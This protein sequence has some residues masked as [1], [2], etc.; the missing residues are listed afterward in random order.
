MLWRL[1]RATSIRT[2]LLQIEDQILRERRHTRQTQLGSKDRPVMPVFR[3]R[4]P[5]AGVP[6]DDAVE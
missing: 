4:E 5:A 3:F 6:T 1:R 2:G